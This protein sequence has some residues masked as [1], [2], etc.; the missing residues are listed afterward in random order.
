MSGAYR[1]NVSGPERPSS[2]APEFSVP[3]VL[4]LDLQP[5]LTRVESD[6]S[7]DW[8]AVV[9][10]LSSMEEVFKGGPFALPC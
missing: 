2:T 6:G 3:P 8:R 9:S 1:E 5:N 10:S 7:D 4:S